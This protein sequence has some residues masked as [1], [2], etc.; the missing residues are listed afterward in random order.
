MKLLGKGTY[1]SVFRQD[2]MA[3]KVS[4][5][6]Y[7]EV[8][9]RELITIIYLNEMN[10]PNCPKLYDFDLKKCTIHMEMMEI[11]LGKYLLIEHDVKERGSYLI[12]LCHAVSH[13]HNLGI[14]HGDLKMSNIMIGEGKIVLIDYG[15]SGPSGY[16]L[17]HLTTPAYSDPSKSNSYSADVYSMGII[18]IEIFSGYLFITNPTK[19]DIK[20]RMSNIDPMYTK[21]IKKMINPTP[22]KRLSMS[23]VLTRL[24]NIPKKIDIPRVSLK[25]KPHMSKNTQKN[26]KIWVESV[27]S[28][29][30]IKSP[31]T[32][33]RIIEIISELNVEPKYIQFTSVAILY[34]ISIIYIGNIPFS[35]AILLCPSNMERNI[36]KEILFKEIERFLTNKSLIH[37]IY[38]DPFSLHVG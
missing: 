1:G 16:A 7:Y 20:D 21:I 9:M 5:L 8:Y 10:Y 32:V 36:R 26:L 38:G 22:R 18:F 35:M 37:M 23:E 2:G 25:E 24:S 3:I 4:K 14:V 28:T 12:Q 34:I 13:L 30:D 19:I 29:R 33:E 15:F 31:I 6:H 11:T 17:T 27:I